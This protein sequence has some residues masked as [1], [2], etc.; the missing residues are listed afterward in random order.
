MRLNSSNSTVLWSQFSTVSVFFLIKMCL[1]HGQVMWLMSKTYMSELNF[2][3]SWANKSNIGF[4]APC[5]SPKYFSYYVLMTFFFSKRKWKTRSQVACLQ[6]HEH[7]NYRNINGLACVAVPL[8]F[9]FLPIPSPFWR[10]LCRLKAKGMLQC[11]L[12]TYHRIL[13]CNR[14]LCV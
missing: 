6:K 3:L 4:A 5:F 8:L 14:V 9:P 11:I 1:S 12:I 13:L 10:L 2:Y 7:A